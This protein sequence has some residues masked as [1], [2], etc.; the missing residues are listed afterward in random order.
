MYGVRWWWSDISLNYGIIYIHKK[1]ST[2]FGLHQK[3]TFKIESVIRPEFKVNFRALTQGFNELRK[4]I[5]QFIGKSG[6]N[7]NKYLSQWITG[8]TI[9]IGNCKK[10]KRWSLI[11][12]I[13]TVWLIENYI[14]WT[15]FLKCYWRTNKNTFPKN[16]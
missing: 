4:N 9:F 6:K 11:G 16:Y 3:L 7:H 1:N 13:K 8:K 2:K 14:Y 12:I 5:P 15:G 10:N